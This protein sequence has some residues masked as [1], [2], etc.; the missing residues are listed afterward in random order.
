MG[1]NVKAGLHGAAPSLTDLD[2]GDL[3]FTS[4]F[5]QAYADVLENWFGVESKAVLGRK[6]EPLNVIG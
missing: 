3:K 5:R 6:F 2:S 4:D 1:K